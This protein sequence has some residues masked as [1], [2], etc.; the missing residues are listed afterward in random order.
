MAV[1]VA[2]GLGIIIGWV[3]KKVIDTISDTINLEKSLQNLEFYQKIS[4]LRDGMKLTDFVGELARWSAIIVFLIA[5]VSSLQIEGADMVFSQVFAY[6]TNVVL[7]SLYLIFGFVIAWFIQRA[8]LAIGTLVGNHPASLVANV[9]FSAF[10][11]FA[12]LQALM[13]LGVTAEFIRLII[14]STMLA[15]AL[16]IGLAGKEI[17]TDLVKKATDKFK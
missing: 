14:I 9:A 6:I 13:Q 4:K 10:V 12:F 11:V 8:I 15:G 1:V 2:I 7:A 3:L 16:A 5:A 17:A